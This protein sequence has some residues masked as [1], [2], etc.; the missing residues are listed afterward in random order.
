MKEPDYQKLGIR[1]YGAGF[2][3]LKTT[4]M[5]VTTLIIQIMELVQ[6]LVV[7]LVNRNDL[8]AGDRLDIRMKVTKGG[9]N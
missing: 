1:D 3:V 6:T 4:Q 9:E 2:I 7:Q 8:Q 5:G